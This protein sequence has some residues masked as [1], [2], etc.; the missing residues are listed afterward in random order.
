MSDYK[1]EC[2]PPLPTGGMQ[3]GRIPSGVKVTHL[4]TGKF[5][6]CTEHRLQYL[7]RDAALKLL[8]AEL[9][10]LNILSI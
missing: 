10:Q 8:I 2:Y 1:V 3:T 5:A 4:P 7:N 9:A 6:I